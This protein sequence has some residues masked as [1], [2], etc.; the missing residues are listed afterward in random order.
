MATLCWSCGELRDEDK[1]P[2]CGAPE[3]KPRVPEQEKPKPK[4]L[5]SRAKAAFKKP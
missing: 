3:E 1:C 5:L 2:Q 4:S